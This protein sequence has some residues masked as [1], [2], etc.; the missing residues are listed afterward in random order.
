MPEDEL[1]SPTELHEQFG[2]PMSRIHRW[3]HRGQ[4]P[5]RGMRG[6]RVKLYAKNDVLALERDCNFDPRSKPGIR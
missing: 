3:H 1:M 4:L 6:T 2:V 5:V